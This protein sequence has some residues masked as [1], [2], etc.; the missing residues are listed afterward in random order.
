M[1]HAKPWPC[2]NQDLDRF[3]I[4]LD[5]I[6]EW[7]TAEKNLVRGQADRWEDVITHVPC[8]GTRNDPAGR[9]L[10]SAT[11]TAIDGVGNTLGSAG[12]S[13]VWIDCPGV[14]I[15]GEM[16][17]DVD[18]LALMDKVEL[19]FLYLHEIGHVIGFGSNWE[20]CNSCY[21]DRD[22]E[23]TCTAAQK[24]YSDMLGISPP[25]TA[26]IV[27][28]RGGAGTRCGHWSE[29]TF[30]DE[31]MTGYSEEGADEPLSKLTVAS[32][33][34]IGYIID[35]GTADPYTL[36]SLRDSSIRFDE[37]VTTERPDVGYTKTK[38]YV[39]SDGEVVQEKTVEASVRY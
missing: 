29:K 34:D 21:D 16:D 11:Q 27:E 8:G 36:P 4:E 33:E 13:Y 37:A 38:Y 18:D 25:A 15:E 9:L 12:P 20:E 31:V 14:T 1:Q 7:T 24:V 23:W 28:L 2:G 26:D 17:F 32:L 10:I 35:P 30:V 5:Y 39:S 6:G 19:E 3:Y 22:P